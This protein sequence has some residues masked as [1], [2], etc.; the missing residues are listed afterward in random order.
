LPAPETKQLARGGWMIQVGAY[1]AEQDAKQQLSAVQSKASK[2][3][4]DADPFTDTVEKGGMTYYRARFAGLDK[5][6][7]EAACEYLKGNDE[8]CVIVS[9]PSFVSRLFGGGKEEEEDA[10][11]TFP[12]FLR[13][14]W[15]RYMRHLNQQ[16][17]QKKIP[18]VGTTRLTK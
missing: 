1:P 9:V 6:H 18:K 14:V 16:R 10:E 3:L 7:A 15:R 13:I 17:R 4:G 2:L 8:E 12:S 11:W 5:D